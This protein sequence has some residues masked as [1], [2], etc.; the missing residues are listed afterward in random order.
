M[1]IVP[2]YAR[3]VSRFSRKS[4]RKRKRARKSVG[5]KSSSATSR[6]KALKALRMRPRIPAAL[7]V[8]PSASDAA[9]E[10]RLIVPA[11]RAAGDAR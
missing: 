6:M 5:T 11:K 4:R 3:G 7:P 9:K 10:P 1:G 2:T 8:K